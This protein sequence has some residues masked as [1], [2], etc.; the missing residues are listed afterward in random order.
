MRKDHNGHIIQS[1][2]VVYS[3]TASKKR[4]AYSILKDPAEVELPMMIS[5]NRLSYLDR[6]HKWQ[7]LCETEHETCR[8]NRAHQAVN[9]TRPARLLD[10]QPQGTVVDVRLVPFEKATGSYAALSYSWGDRPHSATTTSLNVRERLDGISLDDL[11]RTFTDAIAFCRD[12]GVRYLWIDALCI[13]QPI[14]EDQAGHRDWES[15]SAIMGHIY[16]NAAFT[17]AA[18]GA[19]S[20]EI[21]LFPPKGPF[22]LTPRSCP[23]FVD[24]HSPSVW[25]KAE[26]PEWV[27]SVGE[28]A[29]QQRGWVLQER[30]MSTRLIH[31]TQHTIFWECAELCASEFEPD[32]TDI[33]GLQTL[34][35]L[36]PPTS[37]QEVPA[38]VKENTMSAWIGIVE[39]YTRR[40]LTVVTDKFPAISAIAER[41]ALLTGDEYI[42]GL[43]KSRLLDDLLW[44]GLWK[45]PSYRT[46]SYTYSHGRDDIREGQYVAPTWSW[47]SVIGWCSHDRVGSNQ[48][49]ARVVS[50]S[51]NLVNADN[52]F[53]RVQPGASLKIAGR[54]RH[55]VY[56]CMHETSED[57]APWHDLWF[58]VPEGHKLANNKEDL[59]WNRHSGVASVWFDV[60]GEHLNRAFSVL[61]M[62][63]R[64]RGEAWDSDTMVPDPEAQRISCTAMLIAPI[65]DLEQRY[66]R[67]GQANIRDLNF[68]VGCQEEVVE[69]L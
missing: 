22:E 11:P 39:D 67:I 15:Q 58:E 45:F 19:S 13:I 66:I 6:V 48:R 52:A 56:A 57:D 32:K 46:R 41:V 68:F 4:V 36:L 53:G 12:M 38:E 14:R 20:A 2:E 65:G 24:G 40:N 51:A 64:N 43:W 33:G 9:P 50:V 59:S 61:L 49:L 31:F 35:V 69:L 5:K 7:Q 27:A 55:K 28:S 34:S 18:Q 30:L 8:A 10:V 1:L 3:K 60:A 42:A 54:V 16:A 17:I 25:V 29:L 26:P 44:T 62:I 63:G 21:G 23:L 47:A 37:D